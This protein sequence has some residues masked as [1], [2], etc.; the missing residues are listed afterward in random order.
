MLAGAPIVSA[1]FKQAVIAKFLVISIVHSAYRRYTM[2]TAP[3]Y[4]VL[5]INTLMIAGLTAS[6]AYAD[7]TII[8]QAH[9]D[10][11]VE[12]ASDAA[13]TAKMKS[14][15]MTDSH[16]KLSNISVTTTN[17]VVTLDGTASSSKAKL[18]A[19][20]DAKT[21][22]GVKSVDNNLTTPHSSKALAKTKKEVSDSW[23]TTKVKS[24]ILADS[25]SKGFD[26]NV[27]TTNGVV[28]LKGTLANQDAI[29]HVKDIA[30]K[31]NGV[32]G[33]DASALVVASK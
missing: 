11:V 24:D 21:I 14:I 15:L 5:L 17:G 2:K 33:V 25:V 9:S 3:L 16:L 28:V 6:I 7:D 23:I 19:E 18:L 26:V 20:T 4:K 1:V 31:V 32:K 30:G 8:P 22:D 12:T 27:V 13:I 29:D 10:G